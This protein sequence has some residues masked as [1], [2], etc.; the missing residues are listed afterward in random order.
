M[1][2]AAWGGAGDADLI[3]L[4]IDAADGLNREVERIVSGL[5][6]AGAS[7]VDRAQQGRH[8]QEAQALEPVVEAHRAAEPRQGLHDQRRQGDGVIDLKEALAAAMPEGPGYIRKTKSPTRP[9]G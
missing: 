7:A 4:V 9:I 8:R 5:R 6:A 3:L 1:V 2:A